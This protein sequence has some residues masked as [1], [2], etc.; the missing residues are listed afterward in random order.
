[1]SYLNKKIEDLVALLDDVILVAE[2]ESKLVNPLSLKNKIGGESFVVFHLKTLKAG[3]LGLKEW[4]R[5]P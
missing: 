3:L 4:S 2:E 5:Y 1:M